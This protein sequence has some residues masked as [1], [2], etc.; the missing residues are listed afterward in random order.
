[1]SMSTAGLPDFDACWDYNHPDLTEA[2]F[3]AILPAARIADDATYLAGLLTQIARSQGLQRRFTHAHATL[4][5]AEALLGTASPRARIRYLLERGRSFNSA[6]ERALAHALFQEAWETAVAHEE[7]AHAVDAAHML[8]IVETGELRLEWNRRALALAEA[9]THERAGRWRASLYNN[10]GWAHYEQ[11][12]YG[13][14]LTYFEQAEA[15]RRAQQ[16]PA[17]LRIARWCVA[18]CIRMLG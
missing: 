15:L 16:Q 2:R 7:D 14:A 13:E 10:L 11:A 12:A 3:L 9:S 18:K 5:A 6:G 17:E 1:M 4:D 8:A